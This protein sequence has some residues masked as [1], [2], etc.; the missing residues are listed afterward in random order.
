MDPSI[1]RVGKEIKGA[2]GLIDELSDMI[3][4]YC[5]IK[6]YKFM[7]Y[8]TR[9]CTVDN[10]YY[11]VI[12]NLSRGIECC[13]SSCTKGLCQIQDCYVAVTT[14]VN[15]DK[16]AACFHMG[17][18]SSMGWILNKEEIPLYIRGDVQYVGDDYY[19][20]LTDIKCVNRQCTHVKPNISDDKALK[21]A[22]VLL[23]A[24]LAK[25]AAKS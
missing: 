16:L 3:R 22:C 9:E 6:D 4:Q 11:P 19:I 14:G 1:A 2:T 13:T 23:I 25:I 5:C 8:P 21:V 24:A 20:K 12:R 15:G 7:G 17:C 10:K 18:L